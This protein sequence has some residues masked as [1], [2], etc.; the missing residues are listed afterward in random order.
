MEQYKKEFIE[1]LGW[2]FSM[3]LIKGFE[4]EPRGC[5][6]LRVMKQRYEAVETLTREDG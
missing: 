2:C 5:W 4:F 1:F 3:R 6:I